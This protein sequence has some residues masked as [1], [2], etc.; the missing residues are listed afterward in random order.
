MIQSV[1][2][3]DLKDHDAHR[4]VIFYDF[5]ESKGIVQITSRTLIQWADQAVQWLGK[6]AAIPK[7]PGSKPG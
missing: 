7:V 2:L 4:A 1:D 3:F 6:P 5:L